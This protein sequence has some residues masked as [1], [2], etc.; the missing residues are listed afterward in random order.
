MTITL[1][2]NGF[3]SGIKY[4]LSIQHIHRNENGKSTTFVPPKKG[5]Q[6]CVPYDGVW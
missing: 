6:H 5:L 4:F 1:V 3:S 2:G